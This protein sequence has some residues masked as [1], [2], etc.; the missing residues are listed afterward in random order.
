MIRS[1]LRL[2]RFQS[3]WPFLRN[4]LT[5]HRLQSS[6]GITRDLIFLIMLFFILKYM[7]HST[8]SGKQYKKD[9]KRMVRLFVESF[10]F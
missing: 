10:R 1:E 4:R 2:N 6:E 8:P 5:L 7:C 9:R 3:S